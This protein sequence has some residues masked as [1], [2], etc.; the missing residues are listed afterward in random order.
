MRRVVATSVAAF[1]VALNA[2]E[3][4][5]APNLGNVVDGSYIAGV[6]TQNDRMVL[7]L[8]IEKL[9]SSGELKLLEEAAAI[10]A[11]S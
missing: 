10:G 8:D 11:V 2:S 6:A 3:V 7:L 9:L 1:L 5:A 4:K